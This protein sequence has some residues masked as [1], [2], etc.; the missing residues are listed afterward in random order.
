[1]SRFIAQAAQ[2]VGVLRISA[3]KP[4]AELSLVLKTRDPNL[5]ILGKIMPTANRRGSV[6]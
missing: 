3:I 6:T 1:M 4:F 5:S 2:G